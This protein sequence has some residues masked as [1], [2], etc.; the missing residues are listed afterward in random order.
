MESG[1]SNHKVNAVIATAATAERR[2]NH[3]FNPNAQG[4]QRNEY[5]GGR[6]IVLQGQLLP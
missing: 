2:A 4:R 3:G 6:Y 5:F 1:G